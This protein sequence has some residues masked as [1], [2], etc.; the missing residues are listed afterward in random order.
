LI[1]ALLGSRS[2]SRF[3]ANVALSIMGSRIYRRSCLWVSTIPGKDLGY[4]AT[5]APGCCGDAAPQ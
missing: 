1:S 2:K 5:I 3:A 4:A